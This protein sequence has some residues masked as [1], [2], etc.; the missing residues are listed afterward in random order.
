MKPIERIIFG[1]LALHEGIN[2]PGIGSLRVE[3]VAARFVTTRRLES[4]RNKVSFSNKENECFETITDIVAEIGGMGKADAAEYYN[5][6]LENS[7]NARD[8]WDIEGVGRIRNGFFS[9]SQELEHTLNPSG[10]Q[11][12][13][14]RKRFRAGRVFVPI[15]FLCIC[16]AAAW[17]LLNGVPEKWKCGKIV[18]Q[19]ISVAP[20]PSV[21]APLPAD[22]TAIET[23][24]GDT[25][26]PIDRSVSAEAVIQK[27]LEEFAATMNSQTSSVDAG[28]ATVYYLSAGVF[29]TV[30]NADKMIA[31]DPLRIGS[32]RYVKY[33]F[34]GGKILVSVFS[35]TDRNAVVAR[36]RELT[37]VDPDLW[38]YSE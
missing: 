24:S 19:E 31:S 12:L 13:F 23:E 4:P 9:P 14:I 16:A 33:P 11:T 18:R 22:S 6:W 2:L 37:P 27:E 36:K 26:S 10:R 1:K 20:I 34:K 38:I 21:A 32:D 7:G 29:S 30:A 8:G 35:S 15:F 25:V 17:L 3:R 5:Q 28:G